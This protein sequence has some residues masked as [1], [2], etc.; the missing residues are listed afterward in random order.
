MRKVH[1]KLKTLDAT[2]FCEKKEKQKLI[3]TNFFVDKD[4]FDFSIKEIAT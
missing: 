2:L 3:I 4:D 1:G